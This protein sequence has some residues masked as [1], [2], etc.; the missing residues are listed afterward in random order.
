MN[1]DKKT[2]TEILITATLLFVLLIALNYGRMTMKKI[3]DRRK[4]T[5]YSSVLSPIEYNQLNPQ[6]SNVVVTYGHSLYQQ[7][8]ERTKELELGR[9]PFAV[10]HFRA[11]KEKGID[12]KL[13]GIIFDAQ[14]PVAIINQKSLRI[15]DTIQGYSVKK[16]EETR[17]ILSDGTKELEL[18]F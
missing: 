9:D 5:L 11:V 13:V 18:A 10:S 14:G 4:K 15:N 3:Q 16:I 6:D 17:V 8:E 2:K 7:L 12:F 1:L